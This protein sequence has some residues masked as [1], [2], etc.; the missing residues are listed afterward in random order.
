[1]RDLVAHLINEGAEATVPQIV[2]ETVEVVKGLE[3]EHA[4]G[5]P[6]VKVAKGLCLGKSVAWRRC[7]EAIGRGH[8]MNLEERKHYPAR[9]VLD[10]PLP[11][12]QPILP[13]PEEVTRLH[14]RTV[15]GGNSNPRPVTG[16][17][18]AP[19]RISGPSKHALAF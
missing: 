10:E 17:H 9:L 6:I 1:M 16:R 15:A 13:S 12:E 2:R 5:V 14:G 4:V 3:G 8:L 7:Q 11:D 19:I 18:Y